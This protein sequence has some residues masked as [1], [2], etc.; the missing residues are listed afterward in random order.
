MSDVGL[1]FNG[2]NFSTDTEENFENVTV[3]KKDDEGERKIKI[4]KIVFFILCLFLIAELVVYKYVMPSF[5][6]PKI[7]VTG[8]HMYSAEEIGV[9][10]LALDSRSW[11][12]FNVE[13]AVAILSSE[14][15]I[16]KAVVEKKFPDKIFVEITERVP[17]AVT[18]IVENGVSNPMQIDRNGF[19]FPVKEGLNADLNVIPIISG[20]PV[21]H[22]AGGLRVPTKF[23]PLIE[24]L[25]SIAELKKNY[26]ASI[27][28]ICVID[29]DFGNYELELIPAQS[30]V[31][32]LTDR[33]LN[34]DALKYMM[35]VLDVINFLETDVSEI[36]LRYGSVSCKLKDSINF[37]IGDIGE[38]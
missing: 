21:E 17:V 10:L 28:E 15:G 32:V 26:F 11:L 9:K 22:I 2:Y 12:D 6:S 16:D 36:D 4:L 13:G 37:E 30:K 29:K 23:R 18:F 1:L 33:S 34:E 27:S 35:V 19:L 31:K 5:A 3:T 25:S 7:T 20:L 8:N 14:P 38:Q 24:Q